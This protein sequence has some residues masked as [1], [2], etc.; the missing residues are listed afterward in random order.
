MIISYED[1]NF[2]NK[3]VTQLG[4]WKALLSI[5]EFM[6]Q[7]FWIF[8]IKS[9][10]LKSRN[11]FQLAMPNRQKKIEFMNSEISEKI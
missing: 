3:S 11:Q 7:C 10:K 4:F 9:K 8:L 1:Q 2:L 6:P 5:S